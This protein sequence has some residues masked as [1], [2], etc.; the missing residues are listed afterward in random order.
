LQPK[1]QMRDASA[2]GKQ[3]E[4]LKRI[5]TPRKSCLYRGD[6]R[7]PPRVQRLL[8]ARW[9]MGREGS[10]A[11]AEGALEGEGAIE[12]ERAAEADVAAAAAA[13]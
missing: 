1:K 8:L 10:L 11:A 2:G 3:N 7:L 12:G 9:L 13:G 5:Y 6:A 4:E